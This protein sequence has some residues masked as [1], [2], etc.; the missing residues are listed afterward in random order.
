M[1]TR[2]SVGLKLDLDVADPDSQ[3]FAELDEVVDA[4]PRE[5]PPHCQDDPRVA[6]GFMAGQPVTEAGSRCPWFGPPVLATTIP[7]LAFVAVTWVYLLVASVASAFTALVAG[8][9]ILFTSGSRR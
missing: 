5:H 9:G 7:G 1:V 2:E 8:T 4:A 3:R 6:T